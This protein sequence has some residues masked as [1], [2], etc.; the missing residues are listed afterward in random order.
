MNGYYKMQEVFKINKLYK[1]V[2][3]WL[4]LIVH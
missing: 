2:C 3:P 4:T 1:V